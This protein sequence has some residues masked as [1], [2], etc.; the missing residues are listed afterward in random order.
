VCDLETSTIIR[1]RP[2]FRLLLHKKNTHKED[3]R[4]EKVNI[5][6]GDNIGHSE[7]RKLIRT[8]F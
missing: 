6:A 3:I 2:D 8:C 7:E 1:P 5:L 4:G